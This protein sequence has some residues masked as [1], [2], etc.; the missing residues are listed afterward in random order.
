MPEL[1]CLAAAV[2]AESWPVECGWSR[3]AAPRELVL[4]QRAIPDSLGGCSALSRLR[5]GVGTVTATN[6]IAIGA[7]FSLEQAPI[8][9]KKFSNHG[10]TGPMPMP[11]TGQNT[12]QTS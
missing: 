9:S 1:A 7:F 8:P 6:T 2:A 10:E 11:S 5:A 3:R 4:G 12:C